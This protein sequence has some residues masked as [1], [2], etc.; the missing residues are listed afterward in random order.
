MPD[1][2][3]T[4]ILAIL[5][6]GVAVA[7]GSV[8]A[9]SKG[10]GKIVCWKDKS[11][12]TV[13]CGDRVP[14]EYEDNATKELDKRGV[15][16]KT[17][18][19]AEE[20]AKRK[21]Q[22]QGLARQQEGEQKRLA[23]QRRQDTALINTFSSEKEIDAKRDRDMQVLDLQISQ[24]KVSLKNV[25]EHQA[26]PKARSEGYGKN[27][28]PVPENVKDEMARVAA[29]KQKI[30]QNI[31]A[32]EKEKEEIR[33]RYAEYRKRFAELRGNQPAAAPAAPSP[34]AGK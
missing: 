24:L 17:T 15:T 32:R 12:K 29:E 3:R 23:D 20:A 9:Q 11:G 2:T 1:N 5:A 7:S 19:S 8:M 27:K 25:I 22:Q 10:G 13:G 4:S 28:K 31:A 34:A 14:P 33:A 21:T 16:R 26:D 30:E 18:D 6:L